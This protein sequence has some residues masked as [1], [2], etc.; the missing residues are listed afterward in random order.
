M[1][2]MLVLYS[3]HSFFN[4]KTYIQNICS[5]V[6][7]ERKEKEGE[8]EEEERGGLGCWVEGWGYVVVVVSG[9]R[10]VGAAGSRST[11]ALQ[12]WW[13]LLKKLNPRESTAASACYTT[14]NQ[15]WDSLSFLYWRCSMRERKNNDYNENLCVIHLTDVTK[16]KMFTIRT[17]VQKY[18]ACKVLQFLFGTVLV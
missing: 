13:G 17:K 15:N 18:L 3:W 1:C 6:S 9:G 11:S 12:I 5:I 2:I 14:N 8:V 16:L 4:K 7:T 10:D